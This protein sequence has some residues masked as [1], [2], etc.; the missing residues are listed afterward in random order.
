[1]VFLL[2]R[3]GSG[4]LIRGYKGHLSLREHKIGGRPMDDSEGSPVWNERGR[5]VVG[6]FSVNPRD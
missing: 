3:K 5:T 6:I 1:M 2:K 4:Y